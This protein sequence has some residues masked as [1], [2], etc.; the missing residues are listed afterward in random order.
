[1]LHVID[2]HMAVECNPLRREHLNGEG[3][4]LN[5]LDPALEIS[6]LNTMRYA[7]LLHRNTVG[8]VPPAHVYQYRV[9]TS[10]SSFLTG[11]GADYD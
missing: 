3:V 11:H 5:E 2:F 9:S 4:L 7:V 6:D 1:M 8:T 10:N